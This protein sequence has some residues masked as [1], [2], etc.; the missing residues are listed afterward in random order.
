MAELPPQDDPL[1]AHVTAGGIVST[2]RNADK[3]KQR[4]EMKQAGD[5]IRAAKQQVADTTKDLASAEVRMRKAQSNANKARQEAQMLYD[6]LMAEDD[7]E[8]TVPNRHGVALARQRYD[9]AAYRMNHADAIAQREYSIVVWQ[10]DRVTA[11]EQAVMKTE[12]LE[13]RVL[14]M[15]EAEREEMQQVAEYRGARELEAAERQHRAAL[16][17]VDDL[18]REREEREI[19]TEQALMVAEEGQRKAKHRLKAAS[20]GLAQKLQELADYRRAERS[21][22]QQALLSLKRNSEEA[23]SKMAA[24]NERNRKKK[25]KEDAAHEAERKVI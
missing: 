11:A 7:A 8:R 23:Y 22:Q 25:L 24:L 10:Q 15:E 14:E 3:R 12:E 13:R 18:Q 1:T 6:Q 17:A 20:Q 19:R 21:R 5:Y 16:K 4:L 9:A 2:Y